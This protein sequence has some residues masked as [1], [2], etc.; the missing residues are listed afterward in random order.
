MGR[1]LK[2]CLDLIRP[3]LAE[4]VQQQQQRQKWYHDQ[5]AKQRTFN[6]GNRIYA[7][8]Y[9]S[10]Q[11]WVPGEVVQ[12]T[13][14]ASYKYRL[15]NTSGIVRKHVDQLRYRHPVSTPEGKISEC[16]NP[17]ATQ[18]QAE[19]TAPEPASSGTS[20]VADS[21]WNPPAEPDS[22][23]QEVQ[24]ETPKCSPVD[25]STS[26]T[27]PVRRSQRVSKPPDRLDL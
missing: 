27:P 3:G 17:T 9:A 16:Q 1:K 12:V 19:N 11:A 26:P 21:P 18:S 8:N 14:P 20:S 10:G 7:R 13:G 4:H 6:C 5:H 22:N 24:A 25:A 23:T 15:D 2:T